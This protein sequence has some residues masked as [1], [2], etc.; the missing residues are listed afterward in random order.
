MVKSADRGS[1]TT[2]VTESS[3]TRTLDRAFF[4]L[5]A[6]AE[7]PEGIGVTDLAVIA[8]L[9]K[10]TV[11]RL[12]ASMRTLGYLHQRP[13]DRKYTLGGRALWLARH[14][15]DAQAVRS[16]A[17]PY[18]RALA[19]ETGET[20][21][22]AIAEGTVMNYV[23]Q[24]DPNNPIRLESTVGSRLALHRAATGRAV[25]A[26]MDET[27]RASMLTVLTEQFTD[28]PMLAELRSAIGLAAQRGWASVER[29]DDIT[30]LAAAIH[31]SSSTPIAGV[32][33]SGPSFRVDGKT[34]SI[35]A[36]CMKA[37]D[38][39]SAALGHSAT[40]DTAATPTKTLR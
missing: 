19:E 24:I 38:I 31:D 18:L 32:S 8:D 33:V 15:Q 37:A 13:D 34:D 22:L 27:G 23:L 2:G 16:I 14:Y 21:H 1:G 5:E 9:D 4:L 20:V 28:D 10:A 40:A 6:V 30:R 3:S 35:A 26:A 17:H 39:I 25:L 7:A 29:G 11:S 36:S 12:L